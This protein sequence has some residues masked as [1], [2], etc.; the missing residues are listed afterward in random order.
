MMDK[1]LMEILNEVLEKFYFRN[2]TVVETIASRDN[3]Y[4]GDVKIYKINN[5]EIYIRA[6]F[7]ENSYSGETEISSIKFV[8]P[9]T[10]T[11]TYFK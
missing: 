5:H 9:D 8:E 4:D 3:D 1:E 7:E 10:L 11:S 6:T 2:C